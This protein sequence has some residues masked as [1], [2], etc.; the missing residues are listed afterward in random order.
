[1]YNK[2]RKKRLKQWRKTMTDSNDTPERDNTLENGAKETEE[3]SISDGAPKKEKEQEGTFEGEAEKEDKE[4]APKD[5]SPFKL[6]SARADDVANFFCQLLEQSPLYTIGNIKPICQRLALPGIG[7]VKGMKEV[8]QARK[9]EAKAALEEANNREAHAS[10]MFSQNNPSENYSF[11][12]PN[13]EK[14]TEIANT[15]FMKIGKDGRGK[16]GSLEKMLAV[17]TTDDNGNPKIEFCTRAEAEKKGIKFPSDFQWHL[18][19]KEVEVAAKTHNL[20]P[21]QEQKLAKRYPPHQPQQQQPQQQQQQ[22]QQQQPQPQQQQQPQQRPQPQPQQQQQEPQGK[23]KGG[24]QA[25]PVNKSPEMIA[26]KKEANNLRKRLNSAKNKDPNFEKTPDGQLLLN[27]IEANSLNQQR[28]RT[29]AKITEGQ[30]TNPAYDKTKSGRAEWASLMKIDEK[31]A[32]L[33]AKA[34]KI[35]KKKNEGATLGSAPKN[36]AKK[37]AASE[38]ATKGAKRTK[39]QEKDL[40]QQAKDTQKKADAVKGAIK[41]SQKGKG[42]NKSRDNARTATPTKQATPRQAP[43]QQTGR[44]G[45]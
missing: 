18:T 9:E 1:M 14:V 4:K 42:K 44:G 29:E 5:L 7:L 21:G 25:D 39:Q 2:E 45:R 37:R 13:G 36:V 31:Q 6:P 41:T 3:N 27:K 23:R 12:G 26:A 11:T 10:K 34:D 38:K 19:P 17:E 24:R 16:V 43:T 33:K 20:T 32:A 28:I 35:E 8:Y 30:K 15:A 22:Q 40:K